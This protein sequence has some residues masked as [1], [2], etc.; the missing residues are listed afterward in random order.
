MREGGGRRKEREMRGSA[1]GRKAEGERVLKKGGRKRTP[2][3]IHRRQMRGGE[4]GRVTE[5]KRHRW[6]EKEDLVGLRS[7]LRR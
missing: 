2:I 1:G 5:T 7:T 3:Q 6:A 4:R